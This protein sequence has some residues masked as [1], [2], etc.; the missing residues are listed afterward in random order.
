MI[1]ER[2]L[3]ATRGDRVQ[4]MTYLY[5]SALAHHSLKVLHAQ[6][7]TVVVHLLHVEFGDWPDLI[8]RLHEYLLRLRLSYQVLGDLARRDVVRLLQFTLNDQLGEGAHASATAARRAHLLS[9]SLAVGALAHA[10]PVTHVAEVVCTHSGRRYSRLAHE[11]HGRADAVRV[12]AVPHHRRGGGG[13]ATGEIRLWKRGDHRVRVHGGMR[14]ARLHTRASA[15]SALVLSISPA[16]EAVRVALGVAAGARPHAR[17]A[18]QLHHTRL[19]DEHH[20][21]QDLV[22]PRILL[23]AR[24]QV[25]AV[26]VQVLS[27]R[28][29]LG[30]LA[31]AARLSVRLEHVLR[32]APV[33]QLA[34]LHLLHRRLLPPPVLLRF[35]L[36]GLPDLLFPKG[37][38]VVK[39]PLVRHPHDALL[40]L[41]R[42]IGQR[43]GDDRLVRRRHRQP[44]GMHRHCTQLSRDGSK[45]RRLLGTVVPG[46]EVQW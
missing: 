18:R 31:R 14:H 20:S 39:V 45:R 19:L 7:S 8:S 43:Q 23:T 35:T 37:Q 33:L 16:V 4:R 9:S 44:A 10:A 12:V 13:V 46:F 1:A 2:E 40:V 25:V 24:A 6:Q 5:D 3:D 26:S 41:L 11:I 38:D 32:A 42:I 21:R 30:R 28:V 27:Q 36:K 29:R 15:K 34:N 17:A 22:V